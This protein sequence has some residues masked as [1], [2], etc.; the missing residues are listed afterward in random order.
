MEFAVRIFF[1]ESPHLIS[2]FERAVDP[3][4][5]YSVLPSGRMLLSTAKVFFF[6]GGVLSA[7]GQAC[8]EHVSASRGLDVEVSGICV[9]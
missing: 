1:Q 7:I 9:C 5:F 4:F 2:G 6:L 3:F 8:M